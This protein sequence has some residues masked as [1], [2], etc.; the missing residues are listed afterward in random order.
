MQISVFFKPVKP[1]LPQRLVKD[2][3]HRVCQVQG[4]NVRSHRDSDAVILILDE[5]VFRNAGA[6]FSKH[7]EIMQSVMNIGIALMRLGR[8]IP[9]SRSWV[10]ARKSS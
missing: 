5:N 8:R 9:Y 10:L 2:D 4:P 6:L 7:D 3:C 1:L